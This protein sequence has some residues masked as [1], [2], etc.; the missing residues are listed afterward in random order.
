MSSLKKLTIRATIW[1]IGGY[2]FSQIWRLGTN[3]ILTRLLQPEVFGL[4]ALVNTF[5]IGI[6]LFSDI[7]LGPSIIQNKRGDDPVFL[8]TAWT[9]QIIRS[10]FLWFGCLL[11]AWPVSKLYNDQRLLLLIPIIGLG[12]IISGLNSTSLFTLNRQMALRQISLFELGGQII[13]T[14]MMMIWAFVSPT[15][16]ALV[17]SSLITGVIQVLW[18][19]RLNTGEPNRL[20][21]E[22]K[23]LKELIS[24][25]KW[26]FLSTAI[27]FLASQTDRLILGKLLS[28]EML[29]V[30]GIAFSLSDIPRSIILT[31]NGKV[32]FPAMSRMTDLPRE[33]MR[34]KILKQRKLILLFAAL[35]L[36]FPICF[37]DLFIS[38]LYDK[39]Y[40]QA[41]WMMPILALGLWHT[42]LY[43]SISAAL[44]AIGKP[45]Y[46]A[47]SSLFTFINLSVGMLIGFH[48]L[49]TLGAVIAVACGDIPTYIVTL[50]GLWREKL[51]CFKQDIQA[52]VVFVT[53]LALIL[54]SRYSLGFGFPLQNLFPAS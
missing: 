29:G 2:G 24:F 54:F 37:G 18:S 27:F 16:W 32:I 30:Y 51:G 8:N 17:G 47:K 36:I 1:T 4:M 5:I 52:T 39:R 28:F 45:M 46:A 26:I 49:G 43:S 15:I 50:Y 53:L 31:L 38:F 34:T 6:H 40:I 22:L 7:G 9:L 19:H 21:W 48:Y 42:I 35:I 41:T 3:L 11:I 23:A 13:S 12:T 10:F 33:T 14:T 25:G 20:A 44:V